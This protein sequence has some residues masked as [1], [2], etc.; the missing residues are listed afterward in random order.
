MWIEGLKKKKKSRQEK[1]IQRGE[2]EERKN[3]FR[4]KNGG[5]GGLHLEICCGL[6]HVMQL[7]DVWEEIEENYPNS[8]VNFPPFPPKCILQEQK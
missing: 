1:G 6:E 5:S 3:M 7:N 2:K 4:T 8:Q